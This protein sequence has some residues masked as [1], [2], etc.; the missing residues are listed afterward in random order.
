MA[1]LPSATSVQPAPSRRRRRL[2][3]KGVRSWRR[4]QPR[5]TR[6]AVTSVARPTPTVVPPARNR[7]PATWKFRSKKRYARAGRHD[8]RADQADTQHRSSLRAVTPSRGRWRR[9]C[10][11]G[12]EDVLRE[13][14][15]ALLCGSGDC[16]SGDCQSGDCQRGD[17]HEDADPQPGPGVRT[18]RRLLH[19]SHRDLPCR[20]CCSDSGLAPNGHGSVTT[21][22]SS[23]AHFT[24]GPDLHRGLRSGRCIDV[25]GSGWRGRQVAVGLAAHGRSRA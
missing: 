6:R 10:G 19:H 8:A 5:C 16:Q 14:L 9:G 3:G 15:G 17:P 21:T 2:R 12:V 13:P 20:R 25:A 4:S 7:R 18:L 22:E 24:V 11:R 1:T 23:T